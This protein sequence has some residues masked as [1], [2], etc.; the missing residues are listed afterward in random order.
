MARCD[1]EV[2]LGKTSALR[3]R[4]ANATNNATLPCDRNAVNVTCH[5]PLHRLGKAKRL[6]FMARLA[7]TEQPEG[8]RAICHGK[9]V[10]GKSF[11]IQEKSK[12]RSTKS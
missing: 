1:D 11:G 4:G 2:G 6:V 12:S 10:K 7:V 8:E 5:M 9:R 3:Q